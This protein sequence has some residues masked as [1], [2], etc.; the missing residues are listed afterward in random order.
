VADSSNH[1][2]RKLTPGAGGSVTVSTLPAGSPPLNRPADLA[3]DENG[4]LFI[5]DSSNCAIRKLDAAG[6]TT[7]V[8]NDNALGQSCAG[9]GKIYYPKGLAYDASAKR[10]YVAESLAHRID[11]VDLTQSPVTV[12]TVA[13]SAL[14]SSG[15]MDGAGDAARFNLPG[16]LALDG[17]GALWVADRNNHRLRRVQLGAMPMVETL[18]GGPAGNMDGDLASARFSDPSDVAVGSALLV[19]DHGND[20]LRR[21]VP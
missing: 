6:L 3:L 9:G 21:V 5:A 1:R 7:V 13:G 18:A 12:T 20:Q 8:A 2:I 15:F 11:V 17:A 4:A 10:L 19:A 16:G 14:G